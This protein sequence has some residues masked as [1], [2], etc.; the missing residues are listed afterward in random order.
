MID[1]HINNPKSI[2]YHVK[3][4]LHEIKSEIRNKT[5]IDI[6]AGNGATSEILMDSGAR[7][8]PFDLFPEYFMLKNIECIRADVSDKIP[9]DGNCADMLICQEGIEHFSDQLKVFKE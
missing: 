1:Q 9:V 4:Y 8:K 7:V 5:V 3:N 6:P 2:K